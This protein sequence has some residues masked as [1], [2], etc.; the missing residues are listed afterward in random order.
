MKMVGIEG[1]GEP[2][3]SGE[4]PVDSTRHR[5]SVGRVYG[6]HV[7]ITKE[8]ELMEWTGTRGKSDDDDMRSRPDTTDALYWR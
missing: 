1:K 5:F 3:V 6:S 7:P 2:G 8:N 4:F